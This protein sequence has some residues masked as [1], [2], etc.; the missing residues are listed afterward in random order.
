MVLRPNVRTVLAAAL[1]ALSLPLFAQSVADKAALQ[2]QTSQQQAT[3]PEQL[4]LRASPGAKPG[5]YQDASGRVFNVTPQ[6]SGGA[7]CGP[8][9]CMVQVCG[10]GTCSYF[11]CTVTSCKQ[12][13]LPAGASVE[14][15]R[16]AAKSIS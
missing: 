9:G 6:E 7:Q 14:P 4:M 15:K 11:F 8:N 3:M 10:S 2:A 16:R 5:T 12:I 1:F 13:E